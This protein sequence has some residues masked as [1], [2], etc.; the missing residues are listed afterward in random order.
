[1]VFTRHGTAMAELDLC[2]SITKD[3][4]LDRIKGIGQMD[5]S[6]LNINTTTR[7]GLLG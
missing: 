2:G 4:N 5:Q 1:M 3:S 7:V 6:G